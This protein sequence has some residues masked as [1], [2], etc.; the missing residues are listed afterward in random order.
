MK[1]VRLICVLATLLAATH[2]AFGEELPPP[3]RSLLSIAM[4]SEKVTLMLP[5][6]WKLGYKDEKPLQSIYE[7]V[8]KDQSVENWSEMITVQGYKDLGAR[9]GSS[10]RFFLEV[11]QSRLRQP[12]GPD[13]ITQNLGPQTIDGHAAHAVILGCPKMGAPASG[14]KI[15]QSEI[16]LYVAIKGKKD[17]YLFHHAMRGDAFDPKTPPITADNV[18]KLIAKTDP[19]MVC[20]LDVS[21]RECYEQRRQR[22]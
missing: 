13:F 1:L 14:A 2:G 21:E 17:M 6:G 10:P 5:A 19:L 3:Q 16:A 8:P 9:E 18:S 22:Q 15:G 7:L 12:C 11:L 4:F 20:A